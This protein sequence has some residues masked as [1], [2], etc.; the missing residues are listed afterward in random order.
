MIHVSRSALPTVGPGG[1]AT[2]AC[3]NET[4]VPPTP[5]KGRRRIGP[6]LAML[7]LLLWP[8]S[9]GASEF[10]PPATTP[11][12]H[13]DDQGPSKEPSP[14][15]PTVDPAKSP[16]QPVATPSANPATP[17]AT[18]PAGAATEAVNDEHLKVLSETLVELTGLGVTLRVPK[19][20]IVEPLM[21]ASSW[22]IDDGRDAPRYLVRVQ[23]MVASSATSSPEAQFR[24]HLEFLVEKGQEYTILRDVD[25]TLD[26]APTKLSYLSMDAGDGVTAVTGWL[27]VQTGPNTFVVFSIISSGVDF[28]EADEL[29]AASFSTISLKR[30]EAVAAVQADKLERTKRFLDSLTPPKL[31]SLADGRP[32]WFRLYRPGAGRDGSDLEM[33]FLRIRTFE[34]ERGEVSTSSTVGSRTQPE[35]GL[36]VEVV[37]KMLVQGDTAHTLDLQSRYWMSWDRQAECWSIVSTERHAGLSSTGGQTGWRAR[38]MSTGEQGS[39]LTVVN[40]QSSKAGTAEDL[41]RSRQSLEWEIPEVGYINQA[42]VILLGALLPRDGSLDGDFSFYWYDSRAN[43]LP[44]RIDRWSRDPDGSGRSV[45]ISRPSSDSPEMKQL[46][47]RDG[48]RLRRIDAD[49]L[50]TEAIEHADLLRIWRTKGLPSG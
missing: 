30:L 11:P 28:P 7:L 10:D 46:F 40:S 2:L 37:A 1:V 25:L 4:C 20:A 45:L 36:M 9:A 41:V 18:P 19:G 14:Q 8:A 42:E 50:V 33:G 44:Q 39:V 49:G 38:P 16:Q 23:S 17:P 35:M 3:V 15:A 48:E 5:W 22:R 12:P 32:R 21:N 27:M 13:A 29:L 34:G 31:R 47:S 24:Q 43:K 26:G 6:W